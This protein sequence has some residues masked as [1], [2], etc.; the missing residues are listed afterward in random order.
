MFSLPIVVRFDV[1]KNAGLGLEPSSVSFSVNELDFRGV[2]E[3]R[4]PTRFQRAKR[5]RGGAVAMKG[6]M[7]ASRGAT[8]VPERVR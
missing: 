7:E 5:I 1:F 8:A 2:K 6:E 4:F 3:W